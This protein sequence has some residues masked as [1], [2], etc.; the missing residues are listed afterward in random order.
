VPPIYQPEVAAR[1]IAWAAAHPRRQVLVGGSTWATILANRILPGLLDRY[2]GRTGFE[3][4]QTEEPE[5]PDRPE[6]L[7][8][9]VPGSQGARGRF[10][11]RA[12]SRSPQLWMTTHRGAVT[13]AA[14]SLA[15]AVAVARRRRRYA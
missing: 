10:D 15:A 5:D 11:D 7:Y 8:G 13:L 6:N 14:A 12:S 3:A 1:A 4:Q 2:L 9:P